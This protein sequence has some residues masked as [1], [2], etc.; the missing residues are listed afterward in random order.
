M[1]NVCHFLI[2]YSY[3]ILNYLNLVTN[4]YGI[5]SVIYV[6]YF[7]FIMIF[8]LNFRKIVHNL[9]LLH[10]NIMLIDKIQ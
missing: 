2:K 5:A 7:R 8:F 10:T 6:Y 9:C 1:K 3:I 4:T